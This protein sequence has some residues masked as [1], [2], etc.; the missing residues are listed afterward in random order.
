[1][2]SISMIQS[3]DFV[4][5]LKLSENELFTKNNLSVIIQVNMLQVFLDLY[6]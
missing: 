2:V 5:V 1:M 4:T 6:L 3:D